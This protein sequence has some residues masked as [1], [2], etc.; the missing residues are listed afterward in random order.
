MADPFVRAS[1]SRA[2]LFAVI[3]PSIS[4]NHLS[5][6]SIPGYSLFYS[7]RVDTPPLSNR[8]HGGVLLYVKNSLSAYVTAI[9]LNHGNN[10]DQLLVKLGDTVFAFVYMN[11]PQSTVHHRVPVPIW[12]NLLGSLVNA[13]RLPPETY[14]PPSIPG[15]L[16][17]YHTPL[18]VM[19]DFN[20]HTAS[21]CPPGSDRQYRRRSSDSRTDV[22]GNE[23]L[24]MCQSLKL[25]IANGFLENGAPTFIG[26]SET[27]P[28]SVIDYMLFSRT[29]YE[30]DRIQSFR[31]LPPLLQLDHTPIETTVQCN[32]P[33]SKR[34]AARQAG[35]VK[36]GRLEHARMPTPV[37]PNA[38]DALLSALTRTCTLSTKRARIDPGVVVPEV[39]RSASLRRQMTILVLSPGFRSDPGLIALYRSLS[40]QRRA[41]QSKASRKK[42]LD[43]RDKLLACQGKKEYWDFVQAVRGKNAK[44]FIDP[45]LAKAHF[46]KLL[47]T[48]AIPVFGPLEF[49]YT[50]DEVIPCLDDPITPDE[51]K[52]ALK[53]M[54]SSADGEDRISVGELKHL[55]VDQIALFFYEMTVTPDNSLP[56]SWRRSILIPIPK[57]GNGN[58]RD[59]K[60]FRGLSVQ[61]S[62]KRLFS[63]CLV[64]RLVRWMDDAGMVPPTQAGFRKGFR[65]TDNLGIL[66]ALHERMMVLK[67]T[68]YVAFIDLEKAF[69]NVD[70]LAL[71][72]LIHS[73]GGKGSLVDVL[74]SLYQDTTTSLRVHGRYSEL[75]DV[76]KG[77]LQGDPLSPILFIMYIGGLDVQ[78]R[79]DPVL[80]GMAI[81]DALLADDIMLPSTT[82]EGL[83]SKLDALNRYFTSLSMKVNA[84]KSKVVRLGCVRGDPLPLVVG[85]DTL[86]E[87]VEY[88]YVGYS[89]NGGKSAKW[90]TSQY[91]EKCIKK[92][93][94]VATSLLQ[95]RSFIG[96][97][98][99]DFM[100][101]LWH[102]LADP[103]F[104]FGAEVSLDC[105][106]VQEALMDQVL[107]QYM[108]SA[109]GLPPRSIRILPLLDNA[110]FE[111]RHRRLQLTARF[112]EYAW[113]CDDDRPIRRAL[114]DSM[115]VAAS[116]AYSHGWYGQ[117]AARVGALGVDPTPRRG[118][119]RDVNDAIVKLMSTEWDLL[120]ASSS[121]MALHRI[122][123]RLDRFVWHKKKLPYL[124]ILSVSG[125]RAIA[126]VRTSSHNLMI[127]RGRHLRMPLVRR[128]CP[129]CSYIV[130]SEHHA[131]NCCP[132][133]E[134][135]RSVLRRELFAI[136][137]DLSRCTEKELLAVMVQPKREIAAVVGRF[138]RKVLEVVDA[139][140][141]VRT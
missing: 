138:F 57:P 39:K 10:Y 5:L 46:K 82:S 88:K 87:V 116:T 113:R 139:R 56:S 100:M 91:V 1:V 136:E 37:R 63:R 121:R 24:R 110:V 80:A 7:L 33:A 32:I 73:K 132:V 16:D 4:D 79:D 3:D 125:C 18:V 115:D 45:S 133:H 84:S 120:R 41:L 117:F 127:E 108:R 129:S 124:R 34:K 99:A 119:A 95:L 94:C 83:Q 93:R 101:R 28:T 20:A 26:D 15:S 70:R 112:M 58:G 140:Y 106:K 126:R 141:L 30:Q 78:H 44:M 6:V 8:V 55:D 22:F 42:T 54:K 38:A 29:L 17:S 130:E 135:T 90:Q 40:K 19:G 25:E 103:Y 66:R 114:V 102:N 64:P 67:K 48:D 109:M 92:A 85:G 104:V 68:L 118:L 11:Q 51:V 43:N 59:P 53:K 35:R 107:L 76:N 77:V 123:P 12:D 62:I 65:T 105:N 98:N 75:F 21:S 72:R 137:A 49:R 69:D 50:P 134:E 96:P 89:V 13:R 27:C 23:L 86:E 2:D 122:T 71:F 47:R 81:P 52:S 74:R 111:V 36:Y 14:L 60:Q 128:V 61:T 31:V 131:F 9:N 97:S